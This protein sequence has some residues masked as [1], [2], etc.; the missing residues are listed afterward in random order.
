VQR[1]F[2]VLDSTSAGAGGGQA[3]ASVCNFCRHGRRRRRA[4]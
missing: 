1:Y 4:A 2:E 3:P